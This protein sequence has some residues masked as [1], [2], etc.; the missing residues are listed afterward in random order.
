MIRVLTWNIHFLCDDWERRKHN[1]YKTLDS[2]GPY[3][4][5]AFQEVAIGGTRNHSQGYEWAKK[6]Y[7]TEY[8]PIIGRSGFLKWCTWIL[9]ILYY[10]NC[11]VF[12]FFGE[13]IGYL[14]DNR[15]LRVFLLPLYGFCLLPL[16]TFLIVGNSIFINKKIK[17]IKNYKV[18]LRKQNFAHVEEF[19]KDEERYVFVNVHFSPDVNTVTGEIKRL[20]EVDSLLYYSKRQWGKNIIVAGDFNTRPSE[21]VYEIMVKSGF[22]SCMVEKY[23]KEQYTFRTTNPIKTID[24]V[25]IKGDD[26]YVKD[27]KLVGG[28]GDSDHYGLSVDIGNRNS[29]VKTG[30]K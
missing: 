4:A 1:I 20:E 11:Y 18:A 10:I 8:R 12:S 19:E 2:N 27:I 14:F 3:D 9:N 24:Y 5:I 30:N 28:I 23:G 13:P 21:S 29:I 15:I 16:L 22:R 6:D 25:W 26:L 7:Y 17:R